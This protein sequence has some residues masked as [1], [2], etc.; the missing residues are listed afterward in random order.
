MSSEESSPD[1]DI[2]V[3]PLPWRSDYVT[4]MFAVIDKYNVMQEK[5][6]LQAKRQTKKRCAG[7]P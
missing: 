2:Y 7:I 5:K 4:R 3:N 1:D 6:T